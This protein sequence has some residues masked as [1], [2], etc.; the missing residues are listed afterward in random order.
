MQLTL[1]WCDLALISWRIQDSPEEGTPTLGECEWSTYDFAK[2]SKNKLHNIE[3]FWTVGVEG[4]SWHYI[5]GVRKCFTTPL[6]TRDNNQP[7][8]EYIFDLSDICHLELIHTVRERSDICHVELIHTARTRTSM[9]TSHC[10]FRAVRKRRR[11]W[12]HCIASFA[13]VDNTQ[14]LF[15]CN[16][17]WMPTFI[18]MQPP[19][20]SF[21]R[22]R[23]HEQPPANEAILLPGGLSDSPPPHTETPSLD[24]PPLTV[25][26]GQYAFYSNAFLFTVWMSLSLVSSCGSVASVKFNSDILSI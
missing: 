19:R 4:G 17:M 26:S 22:Y 6:S 7:R 21:K 1:I 8:V 2:F 15:S 16:V 11:Q 23:R 10:F 13:V 18:D 20:I 24:R 5:R 9:D 3:K 25:K 14:I 12:T